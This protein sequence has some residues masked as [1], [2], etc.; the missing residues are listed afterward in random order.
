MR[1]HPPS[2]P[3]ISLP[4][5]LDTGSFFGHVSSLRQKV[6]RIFHQ[7]FS[8]K[9]PPPLPFDPFLCLDPFSRVHIA[10]F[11]NFKDQRAFAQC[12]HTSNQ[13]VIDSRDA[14]IETLRTQIE[15]TLFDRFFAP[16]SLL[17]AASI[18][19]RTKQLFA[20]LPIDL[21][22]HF[23]DM[24]L[25]QD[26]DRPHLKN[27][28]HIWEPNR[29]LTGI[30]FVIDLLGFTS[31]TNIEKMLLN[32][33]NFERLLK[34][35]MALSRIAVAQELGGPERSIDS[36]L[37]EQEKTAITKILSSTDCTELDLSS[38]GL[39][40]LPPEIGSLSSLKKLNLSNK[41]LQFFPHTITDIRRPNKKLRYV[42]Y[43][44]KELYYPQRLSPGFNK[45][46]TLP[47]EIKNL[48]ALQKLT[49]SNKNLKFLPHKIGAHRSLLDFSDFS[50]K[51]QI[52]SQ[53]IRSLQARGV[54]V[55]F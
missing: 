9:T 35:S 21:L 44:I 48:S 13:A 31:C 45:L 14:F 2:I 17:N 55:S 25:I 52:S 20:D 38:L 5:H 42:P 50:N 36:D 6:Y 41:R 53:E 43:K 22:H 12:S 28:D 46:Q 54:Y 10:S 24:T 40:T 1:I 8:S 19:E 23:S 7:I 39:T 47:S 30:H 34:T 32:P 18:R 49:L 51:L 37:W 27:I 26:P 11:L 4:S 29:P 16:N 15:P 3:C 33:H